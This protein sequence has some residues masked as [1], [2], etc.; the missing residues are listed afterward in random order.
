MRLCYVRVSSFLKTPPKSAPPLQKHLKLQTVVGS[1]ERKH[2]PGHGSPSLIP[3]PDC[4]S[5]EMEKLG[6]TWGSMQK[7]QESPAALAEKQY[8]RRQ[9]EEQQRE[10]GG[11]AY[12]FPFCCFLHSTGFFPPELLPHLKGKDT[13]KRSP[14]VL[15]QISQTR[16][17][18]R[19]KYQTRHE[20]IQV[21]S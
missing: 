5:L 8:W 16:E 9:S 11:A 21:V 6:S 3:V 19:S 13:P 15:P 2:F 17:A 1:G 4:Q 14:E 7:M 12:P 20:E 18:M 10:G